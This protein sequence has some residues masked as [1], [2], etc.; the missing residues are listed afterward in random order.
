MC[1][2]WR[3]GDGFKTSHLPSRNPS[4]YPRIT[5]FDSIYVTRAIRARCQ[6]SIP[7][8]NWCIDQKDLPPGEWVVLFHLAHCH[9][10]ETS[11]CDPSQEYL[12]KMT[13]MGVRTVR[14][15][16]SNLENK[17]RIERK[18]RGI[19][20]GGRV[21][22]YYVLGHETAKL[23]TNLTGQS[24]RTNRPNGA[25]NVHE[26][27]AKQEVTGKNNPPNPPRGAGRRVV[28]VSESLRKKVEQGG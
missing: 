19:E 26:M 13:N 12:S 17:G 20:G 14:R 15:H 7:A 27:A 3:Q 23:A 18:K 28:G 2:R 10:H 5:T 24:M 9:N 22:D 25:E 4:Y 11:R 16:L 6:V 1:Y 21:S 8:I